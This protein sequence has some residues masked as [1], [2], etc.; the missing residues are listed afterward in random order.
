V[1]ATPVLISDLEFTADQTLD[2]SLVERV[3]SVVDQQ[4]S[5]FSDLRGS[6]WYK[7]R[8]VRLFTKKAIAQLSAN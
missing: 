3:L 1:A 4:I 8:M 7:R 6:E 2:E 5:P